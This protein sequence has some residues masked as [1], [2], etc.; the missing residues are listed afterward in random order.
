MSSWLTVLSV[1]GGLALT[2]VVNLVAVSWYFGRRTAT[3]D[4][5]GPR[6]DDCE[7][8]SRRFLRLETDVKWIKAEIRRLHGIAPNGDN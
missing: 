5:Y 8:D 4:A 3:Y 6:I 1:L 7:D 2:I